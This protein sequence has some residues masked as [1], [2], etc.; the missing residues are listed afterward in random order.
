MQ[1]QNKSEY[2]IIIIKSSIQTFLLKTTQLIIKKYK[3]L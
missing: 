2:N 1:R 3:L